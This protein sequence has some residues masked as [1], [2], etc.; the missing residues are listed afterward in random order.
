[1][2]KRFK[3]YLENMDDVRKQAETNTDD[4]LKALN[5]DAIIQNPEKTLKQFTLEFLKQNSVLF[6][7]ARIEGIKMAKSLKNA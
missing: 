5:V 6:K 1:M 4:M 2:P 7:K 3:T